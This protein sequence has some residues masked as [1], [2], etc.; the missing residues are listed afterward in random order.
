[1][2]YGAAGSS[3]SGVKNV[4][5]Q[6]A[7]HY[8]PGDFRWPRGQQFHHCSFLGNRNSDDVGALPPRGD[9]PAS[10]A[11]RSRLIQDPQDPRHVERPLA[12]IFFFNLSL[13]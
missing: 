11:P 10:A 9:V 13:S 8:P 1:M 5:L 2:R 4:L 6:I 12:G 7:G 3:P